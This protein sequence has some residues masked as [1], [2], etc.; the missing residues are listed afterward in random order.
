[1]ADGGTINTRIT[2]LIGGEYT[3]N[4]AYAG[5]FINAAI[6]EVADMLPNKLLLRH[7][8]TPGVLESNSTWLVEGRKILEVT[9]IDADTNGVERVCQ[10]VNRRG[11]SSAGDSGSIHEATNFSPIYH[12]D[13]NNAGAAT[14]KILPE[15][16]VP[17]KGK[18]WYFSYVADSDDTTAL[19]A[20]TLNT[21]YYL[22]AELIQAVSLKAS[23]NIL[24][25]Y[26]SNSIQDDEDSEILQM[27]TAQIGSLQGQ[28]TGEMA[29]FMEGKAE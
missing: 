26:I 18:I 29:R 14:L 16:T 22:P 15:P 27:L 25:S 17:Q 3:T 5:D 19:T 7:S 28:F 8:R 4:A 6:N 23:V 10:E 24:N 11:F 20:T 2:D 21:S 13:S 1:M 9:R 12:E